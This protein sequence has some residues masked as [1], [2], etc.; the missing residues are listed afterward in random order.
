MN[1][2]DLFTEE[3]V[4]LD[5][6]CWTGKKIGNPKTKMK[7]GTRV[8]NCVP[9]ESVNEM[10]KSQT[11][12]GRDGSNDSDA[13]KKEY[14]A[15]M[16]TP[17]KAAKDGEKILNKELNKK[18]GVAE[19]LNTGPQIIYATGPRTMG[20]NDVDLV[21]KDLRT[22][23]IVAHV[24]GNNNSLQEFAIPDGGEDGGNLPERPATYEIRMN[25]SKAP[26]Y[27]AF[28]D[29]TQ[30]SEHKVYK[31]GPKQPGAQAYYGMG[32]TLV[33]NLDWWSFLEK[34][35]GEIMAEDDAI[36]SGLV[37]RKGD[38]D[39]VFVKQQGVAEGSQEINWVKPNFDF[40]WHE[41]EEQSRMKQVPVDVR[42]YYQKHFPNKDAWLKAV[43][44][45]KAVVVPPDHNYEIR[46][47]PFD[48]ASLQKALAPTGHE[49]PIGPAKEK[50]VNDLFDK[51]QVEMPIILKTSQ[52]L[53]LIG[54]KTRL[55]TANYVKGLPAKVWLIDDKQG[56]AEEYEL[57]GVGVAYELGRR[58]YKERKTARDNP[59]S[60]TRE[61]RKND[62]WA[63]GLE[64]GQH[65]ANDARHF[66][67]SVREQGVA[68]GKVEPQVDHRGDVDFNADIEV[69]GVDYN[70]GTWKITYNG[71]PYTVKADY[72]SR[73][74]LSRWQIPDYDVE[75]IN[76]NGQNI[77]KVID[78]DNEGSSKTDRQIRMVNTIIAYLDTENAQDIQYMAWKDQELD[79]VTAHEFYNDIRDF[80]HKDQ[81]K[82]DQTVQWLLKNMT[83]DEAREGLADYIKNPVNPMDWNTKENLKNNRTYMLYVAFSYSREGNT[84]MT[85]GMNLPKIQLN[86]PDD[87]DELQYQ[88]DAL[89]KKVE[90]K[91]DAFENKI[92]ELSK[93]FSL[94]NPDLGSGM[95]AREMFWELICHTAWPKEYKYIRNAATNILNFKAAVDKYAKSFNSSLIKIGLPGISEYAIWYGVLSDDL[96]EQQVN[97]FATP[98]GFANVANGKIDV[99]KM[100]NDNMQRKSL[101]EKLGDNRPKLGTKRD[102]GKSVRKWRKARGLDETG[103]AEGNKKP[104][105]PEADYGDDYQDMVAR[106]K[107]LAGLGP[108]KTVYDP[109]KRVYRNMPTAVQPKK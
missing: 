30:D 72:F 7:G 10:D 5:P 54:G 28:G 103:V 90:F 27:V 52:G 45:G 100:I 88:L 89:F 109:T 64:R 50:R 31:L 24:V 21:F 76:R 70:T 108:L 79:N 1:L 38:G 62:E 93:K 78:W 26:T 102:A 53:W 99:S 14:T 77:M 58:A 92:I 48:K 11:P 55:G 68:E 107:K 67:S 3:K 36:E 65:D 47:A 84:E 46:N 86:D 91:F 35:L 51:G 83:N 15:K 75:I 9:A 69:L 106:V 19:G 80:Y 81:Q 61:A 85:P 98:E 29:P 2:N 37:D 17:K 20:A 82:I 49:G 66:R 33:S 71:K 41:V 43:Q 42:Q 97:Y 63:K 87:E 23:K 44:N 95:G 22:G 16:I 101:E 34:M 32:I 39:L 40:E 6:K 104:E 59:Y 57:A 4:R 18:P 96:T 60:A 74:D 105:Q 94:P 13:G 25:N 8:N 73:E 56:V 12:P